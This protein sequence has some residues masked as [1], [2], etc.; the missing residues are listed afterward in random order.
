MKSW[1]DLSDRWK[2]YFIQELK[3]AQSMSKDEDTKVG[4]ILIN[5]ENKVVVSKGWND[6]ARGVK[7]TKERNSRP[8]KYLFTSHAERSCLDN[9]LRLN[10]DI[11]N[12]I[13]LTSLACCPQCTASI[14]NCGIKEVVTPEP[15][16]N[17][18]SCGESYKYS[19]EMFSE[20]GVQWVYQE[21]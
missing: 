9:A 6:C 8:L 3:L 5:L 14:I 4:A 16:F 12:C 21:V 11:S 2:T 1:N 17:H 15:D 18:I 20:A 19:I 10:V 7:N 13:M